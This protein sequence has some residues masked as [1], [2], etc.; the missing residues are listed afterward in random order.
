MDLD[1]NRLFGGAIPHHVCVCVSSQAHTSRDP[2]GA[3][4]P[5]ERPFVSL[6]RL[7]SVRTALVSASLNPQYGF[8]PDRVVVLLLLLCAQISS[9]QLTGTTLDEMPEGQKDDPTLPSA[10]KKF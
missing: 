5:A 10:R 6:G 7:V 1:T 3:A 8:C 4:P 9:T 2:G